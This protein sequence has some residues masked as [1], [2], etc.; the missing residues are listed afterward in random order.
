MNEPIDLSAARQRAAARRAAGVAVDFDATRLALARRLAALPRTLLGKRVGVTPSAI[1]QYEKGQTKPTLPIVE[2]LA[3]VLEVPTEFF[4]AGSPMPSLSASGAHTS[5]ACAPP[6]LWNVNA[7][8]PS[9]SWPLAVF[10]VVELH[11]ELPPVDL[12][13]LLWRKRLTLLIPYRPS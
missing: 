8:W 2:R 7:P 5:A 11:V 6:R 1:T 12:P 9:G 10:T 13:E 4:R 3:E